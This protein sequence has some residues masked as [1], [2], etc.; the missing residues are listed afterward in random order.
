MPK[1][2]WDTPPAGPGEV[3]GVP[4]AVTFTVPLGAEA[5]ALAVDQG[6]ARLSEQDLTHGPSAFDCT[7]FTFAGM[8][9][10]SET[11]EL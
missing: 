7:H 4:R 1:L 11:V 2:N 3:T 9:K 10:K 5:V 6:D 8:P